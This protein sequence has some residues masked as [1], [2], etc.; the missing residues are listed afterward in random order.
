MAN[1]N[2]EPEGAV[3]INYHTTIFMAASVRSLVLALLVTCAAGFT[4]PRLCSLCRVQR[5]VPP[6]SSFRAQ[7]LEEEEL[8]SGHDPWSIIGC[9]AS[10]SPE[11]RR[12]AFFVSLT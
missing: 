12:R 1:P 8:L 11:E 4:S 2:P 3:R 5:A 10:A 6:V 9:D 7:A